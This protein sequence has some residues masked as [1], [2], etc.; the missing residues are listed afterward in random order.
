MDLV[1]VPAVTVFTLT[2]TLVEIQALT[3]HHIPPAHFRI[4]NL[5]QFVEMFFNM[6]VTTEEGATGGTKP[7]TT[8]PTSQPPIN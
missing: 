3:I 5:F 8:Q 4:F 1:C 6:S 7:V 2:T